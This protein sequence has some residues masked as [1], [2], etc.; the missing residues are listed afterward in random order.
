MT[1]LEAEQLR[2]RAI[3]FS[4]AMALRFLHILVLTLCVCVAVKRRLANSD[5]REIPSNSSNPF[6]LSRVNSSS[7]PSGI[8]LG[9]GM[10][11]DP[12]WPIHPLLLSAKTEVLEISGENNDSSR[13]LDY[14]FYRE[15]CPR[16]EQIVRDV[17]KDLYRARPEVAP[18]L[19]RLVFHDCF[20][21]VFFLAISFII[22]V[23]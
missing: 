1:E 22:L 3:F 5:Y 18:I 23:I 4:D 19:L 10:W 21:Q 17:V 16:A 14:D 11:P 15:S 20:I 13:Q 6:S 2:V 12:P 8:L 7:S 9:P